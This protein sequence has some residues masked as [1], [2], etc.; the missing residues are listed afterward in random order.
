MHMYTWMS[1]RVC[2][3]VRAHVYTMVHAHVHV[4]VCVY[5]DGCM[6]FGRRLWLAQ[7]EQHVW[8]S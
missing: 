7:L 3:C 1:V 5:E 4:H 2:S 8:L 6:H